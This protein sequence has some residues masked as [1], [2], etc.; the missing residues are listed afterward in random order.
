MAKV[1]SGNRIADRYRLQ[2]RIGDGGHGEIWA[3]WDELELQRVALK[4]LHPQSCE[5]QEA[6]AVLIHEAQMNQRL[7]HPGLLRTQSPVQD[8][9]EVFLP[10]EYAP[11]GDL[12]QLRGESFHRCV[13]ILIAVAE[14]LDHAHSRGIVHRDVKPGNVLFD[15]LGKVRLADFGTSANVGSTWTLA[16][17]SPFSASPQ[18]LR[19]EAASVSDDVYGLGALAYELLGGNPPYY[20]N[21]DA[22]RVQSEMPAP[23]RPRQPVPPRLSALVMAML[24]REPQHRPEN[25]QQVIE[26][27][28][29]TLSDTQ[30]LAEV[31]TALIVETAAQLDADDRSRPAARRFRWSTGIGLAAAAS[32]AA[33]AWFALDRFTAPATVAPGAA[34]PIL[35]SLP[36]A[37][38]SL[39]PAADAALQSVGDQ[40]KR[41]ENRTQ[42]EFE[43]Q[44]SAANAALAGGQVDQARVAFNSALRLRPNAEVAMAGLLAV[45]KME[46]LLGLYSAGLRAEASGDQ[47]LAAQ[48][49][50]EALRVDSQFAPA[51]EG[52][53]R[54]TNAVTERKFL[55]MI[56]EANSALG[57]AQF[58]RARRL[59]DGSV[60]PAQ[61]QVQAMRSKINQAELAAFNARDQKLGAD[62]EEREQWREAV[63]L[64]KSALARDATQG[65]VQRALTRSLDRVA[66]ATQLEDLIAR[67]ERL[68][69]SAVRSTAE[70]AIGRSQ[71]IV[72]P[73]PVLDAQLARLSAVLQTMTIEAQVE[74]S[75]DNSTRVS[76]ARV[77]DLG[78]FTSRELTLPPGRYTVIG[79]RVGYRDVRQE[80]AI[81]PGLRT[82]AVSVQCTERI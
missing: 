30:S 13:P 59:L 69:A 18:Q 17:G 21:F 25:M 31:G 53:A 6:R 66:L 60:G 8:G 52:R 65:Q 38:S 56:S 32:I 36:N 57:Q 29:L 72:R 71:K 82:V 39:A 14:V 35:D 26:S 44:L 67:P 64:Y 70:L 1:D 10:M 41:A 73:A 48:R 77:G 22:Q 81:T 68:T 34:T 50:E 43:M 62:L 80:F 27:L 37:E 51:L 33:V 79:T 4:F 23:L 12:K 5:N 61:P 2:E 40:L 15:T 55:A 47:A 46:R 63:A 16:A 74:I 24:A 76:I 3:A 75:S 45:A 9:S 42:T 28:R 19:G 7:D 49:F 11:G 58:D 78:A 20:P 54:I